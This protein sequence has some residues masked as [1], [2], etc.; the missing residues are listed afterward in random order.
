MSL[1]DRFCRWRHSR[2]FGIHSPFAYRLIT[3]AICPARGYLYY[4]EL[5]PRLSHPLTA[6][7][8]RTGIFLSQEG[9]PLT[10]ITPGNGSVTLTEPLQPGKSLLLIHPSPELRETLTKRLHDSGQGLLID[11][12]EYLLLVSRPEMVYT[13][14]SL[15]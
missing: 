15:P 6:I 13:A 1:F 10:I 5:T 11:A 9:Y 2:G 3:E 8:Y 14:Y 12:V 7:A 4:E